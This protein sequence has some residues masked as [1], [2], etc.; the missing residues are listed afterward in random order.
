MTAADRDADRIVRAF[1]QEGPVELSA[2]VLAPDWTSD[3]AAGE[4]LW[5]AP[6]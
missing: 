6:S 5:P 3:A 1:L 4:A 2:P